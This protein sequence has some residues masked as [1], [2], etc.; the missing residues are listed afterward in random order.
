[1]TRRCTVLGAGSW[2]TALAIH[3]AR[4]GCDTVLWDRNPARSA[5][6][7]AQRRNPR[8]LREVELPDN[9][10]ST[11]DLTAALAR[12][13]VVVPVV[14]SHALRAALEPAISAIGP[15][16]V[17]CCATKGIE[18]GTGAAMHEVLAELLPD[19]LDRVSLLYGPSFA[20]ELAAGLP[21]AIVCAG[22]SAAT[23]PAIRAFHGG[24]LRVYS[25]DDLVGVA[26][27][28]S[29][30]NV[31]AI[32]CGVSDGAGLGANARAALITRGLAEMT[33]LAVALGAKPL[34]MAG[35]AGMGDLV[36]T[37]T[38]NLS[39]NRRVGLALGQGRTLEDIL[40]ELGEVAEGVG[41]ARSARELGLRA[42]VELPITEQVYAMLHEGQP[43]ARALTE[44]MGRSRKQELA[45][46]ND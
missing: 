7:N 34:T 35:L 5:E 11:S 14:P 37:C 21:T 38:G 1:M 23:E 10:R 12:A 46:I 15:D 31:I 43:A 28:G 22:G 27:G 3:L 13:E 32:A 9:L 8:Y 25:S 4:Q 45:G 42:G 20:A 16:A 17:V 2:G 29:L 36:L 26:I 39:R 18:E 41:T 24:N 40:A 6:I 33:R 19:G 44:L 30:K